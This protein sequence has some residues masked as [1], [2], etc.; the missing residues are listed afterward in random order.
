MRN[1][2]GTKKGAPAT[3]LSRCQA[4]SG[5]SASTARL[6]PARGPGKSYSNVILR[7]AKASSS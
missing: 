3:A 6:T 2:P 7:L 1:A 4:A 5:M